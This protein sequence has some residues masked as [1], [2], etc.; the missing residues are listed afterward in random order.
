VT[1]VIAVCVTRGESF[2]LHTV[3]LIKGGIVTTDVNAP[4]GAPAQR[5]KARELLPFGW[6]QSARVPELAD[7]EALFRFPAADDPSPG[8]VKVLA[9]SLY[10]AMLGLGGV[11]VGI[12]GL[13]SVIGGGVPGWYV[14]VLVLA[15]LLSVVPAVGAFLSVHRP[16]LPWA[17]MMAAAIPLAGA[18]TLAVT[19]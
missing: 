19:Y 11:G 7:P 12:R 5:S 2:A 16:V 18:I 14:P 1:S 3:R 9:M 6:G 10:A 13:I 17:L 15:G 4:A 8:T